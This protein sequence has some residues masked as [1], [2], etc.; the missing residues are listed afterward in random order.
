[1]LAHRL[2]TVLPAM[3]LPE[4]LETTRLHHVADRT[5]ARIALLTTRPC[6]ASHHTLSDGGLIGGA[7]CR[8]P[9]K[10]RWRTTAGSSWTSRRSSNATSWKSCASPS[11]MVSYRYN[12]P[13][14]LNLSDFMS[15]ANRLLIASRS[16]GVHEPPISTVT[17][18][19]PAV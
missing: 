16:G 11:M 17:V 15:L 5:G 4:A 18:P 9:A 1:M 8:C 10:C 3:A 14:I 19:T 7:R 6:R 13:H 12:L 2:T